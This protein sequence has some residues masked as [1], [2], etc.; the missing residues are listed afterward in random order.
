MD[1]SSTIAEAKKALRARL[2]REIAAISPEECL[3]S[4]RALFDRFLSLPQVQAADTLFLFWGIPGRE[5]ETERLGQ[6]GRP[7][8]DAARTPDGGAAV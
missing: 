4:D 3:E 5:P 1:V 6:A 2:R 8:P 7:S